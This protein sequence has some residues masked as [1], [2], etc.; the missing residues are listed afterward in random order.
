MIRLLSR[1]HDR[2]RLL[3]ERKAQ[4]RVGVE[5]YH[6]DYRSGRATYCLPDGNTADFSFERPPHGIAEG[7]DGDA[8]RAAILGGQHGRAM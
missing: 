7:F 2:P 8:V 4:A 1:V 5:S 3:E 6:V